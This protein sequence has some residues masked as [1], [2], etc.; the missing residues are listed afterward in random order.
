MAN[1]NW[2]TRARLEREEG[3]VFKDWGGRLPV[4]LVYP[5][6]YYVGMSN[7]GLHTIY[8][9]LNDD[10]AVVCERVFLPDDKTN[11]EVISLESG[12]PLSDFAVVAFSVSFELD[13]FNVAAILRESG[14]PLY[15][16]ERDARHPLVVGGG[17]CLTANPE[18]LAPFLDAVGIGEAEALLPPL[19]ELVRE[20]PD[21]RDT[22]FDDIICLP[23]WYVPQASGGTVER[24][25]L[26]N[27]D[28]YR[29][30]SAVLT[31][32][33]ELGDLYML[34]VERGCGWGCRFCLAGQV[35]RPVRFRAVDRLLAEAEAGLKHRR[36]LG[37]VG[38]AVSD[39]PQIEDI[40]NGLRE[41]GVQLAVSSLRVNP[42]NPVV[43]DAVLASGARTLA[44]APEAGSQRLRDIIN[45]R[46]GEGD[47][48]RAAE[49]LAGR[50]LNN[51]KL[52][53]MLGLPGET[54]SDID[55]MIRLSLTFRNILVRGNGKTRL[56][57]NVA[58][59]VPKAQTPFQWLPMTGQ[60]VISEHLSRLKAGLAGSGVRIK[61]ES[62]PWS[63]V[64]AVL[65]RGDRRLAPVIA[66]V[67]P[68]SLAAWRRSLAENGLEPLEY[69]YRSLGKNEALPWDTVS[70]RTLR[71]RLYRELEAAALPDGC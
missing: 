71:E 20:M 4:A 8:R 12:R 32:D 67:G 21:D 62:P 50:R 37:L 3:T 22:L 36:R 27:L 58:P 49:M 66:S 43:L 34:E 59:F 35:F 56:S 40:V 54:G 19:L 51:V 38:A 39:H 17:P 46:V 31:R 64:Q 60:A 57:L 13:Y 65:A 30:A 70:G 23:G 9:L 18:P 28:D 63:E 45:K 10:P 48:L 42:L 52:Y 16:G 55:E 24:Q 68:L 11:G 41:M 26:E 29:A 15:A 5:N 2:K 69:V 53:Y 1:D 61:A 7:L 47:I 44:L 6:S 14:L 33:T 25:Y